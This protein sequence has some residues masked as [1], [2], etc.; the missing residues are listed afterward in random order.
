MINLLNS[1]TNT[2]SLSLLI[3]IAGVFF[4]AGYLVGII[5]VGKK[6]KK[7]TSSFEKDMKKLINEIKKS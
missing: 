5:C 7:H 4:W 1:A 6:L 3:I 2:F